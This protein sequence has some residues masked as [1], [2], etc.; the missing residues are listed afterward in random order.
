MSLPKEKTLACRGRGGEREG[1]SLPLREPP[2][3]GERE[4][5]SI[6]SYRGEPINPRP[7]FYTN[8]TPILLIVVSFRMQKGFRGLSGMEKRQLY[9]YGLGYMSVN[10]LIKCQ[11]TDAAPISVRW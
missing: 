3:K 1:G 9:I 10:P 2:I 5:P 11:D 6:L 8:H 7:L 4:P